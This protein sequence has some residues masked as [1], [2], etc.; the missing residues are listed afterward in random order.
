V[1]NSVVG[2]GW[3]VECCRAADSAN[4][5]PFGWIKDGAVDKV[6]H[7]G[8]SPIYLRLETTTHK[9]GVVCKALA[10]AG[11]SLAGSFMRTARVLRF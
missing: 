11:G 7:L 6:L 3:V 5:L 2:P 8:W 4:T 1:R 9:G 10:C